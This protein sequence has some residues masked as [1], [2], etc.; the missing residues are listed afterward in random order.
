MVSSK[1]IKPL[2][3]KFMPILFDIVDWLGKVNWEKV[4]DTIA[5]S[6]KGISKWIKENWEGIKTWTK[7]VGSLIIGFKAL[8]LFLGPLKVHTGKKD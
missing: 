1:M 4:F 8:K 5:K 3:D 2:A 6:L 7:W